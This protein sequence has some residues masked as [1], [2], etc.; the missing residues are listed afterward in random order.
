MA[1]SQTRCVTVASTTGFIKMCETVQ[2]ILTTATFQVRRTNDKTYRL[3]LQSLDP[4]HICVIMV[5]YPITMQTDTGSFNFNVNVKK[6]YKALRNCDATGILEL[7]FTEDVLQ[8]KCTTESKMICVNCNLNADVDIEEHVPKELH[9][10][11]VLC[12]PVENLKQRVASAKDF[13]SNRVAFNVYKDK[14]EVTLKN[15]TGIVCRECWRSSN[16]NPTHNARTTTYHIG[17]PSSGKWIQSEKALLT[18]TF[19]EEMLNR[20]LK[21]MSKTNNIEIRMGSISGEEEPPL[22]II[23]SFGQGVGADA[24]VVKFLVAP[25][26]TDTDD[27]MEY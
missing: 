16:M 20:I 10:K 25:W 8:V 13:D 6:L 7:L 15:E 21:S 18:L 23:R 14:F 19:Q 2:N 3:E 9:W 11:Y 27:D 4:T 17:K 26:K 22:A 24:A 12:M 1:T 5:S